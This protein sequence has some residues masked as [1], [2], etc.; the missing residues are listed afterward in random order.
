MQF[1]TGLTTLLFATL[2]LGA[3]IDTRAENGVSDVD[4]DLKEATCSP[5]GGACLAGQLECCFGL[6]CF[7]PPKSGWEPWCPGKSKEK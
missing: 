1:F 3:A 5:K 4:Q 2:A 6:T 7:I